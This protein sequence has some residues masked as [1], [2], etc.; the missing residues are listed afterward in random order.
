MRIN[1]VIKE[2]LYHFQIQ[3]K[4]GWKKINGWIN[5]KLILYSFN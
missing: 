1:Y 2:K 4:E 3:Q 5:Y